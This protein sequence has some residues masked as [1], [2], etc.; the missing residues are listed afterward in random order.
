MNTHNKILT[1]CNKPASIKQISDALGIKPPS[2]LKADVDVLVEEGA[3]QKTGK[4]RGTKYR[5]LGVSLESSARQLNDKW[6]SARD[7]CTD[8]Y[9]LAPEGSISA[10]I[11]VASMLPKM[12]ERGEI[13]AKWDQDLGAALYIGSSESVGDQ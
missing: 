11:E 3:L 10:P 8:L 4:G 9:A 5:T 2:V 1:T 12:V 13:Q 6:R 7:F